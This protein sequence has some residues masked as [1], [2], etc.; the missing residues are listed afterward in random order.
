MKWIGQ[1]K[2]VPQSGTEG[3]SDNVLS[4]DVGGVCAQG[5]ELVPVAQ[6]APVVLACVH[7]EST[8]E[9]AACLLPQGLLDF[10][11]GHIVADVYQLDEEDV[12]HARC[13]DHRVPHAGE[14]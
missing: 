5:G 8:E 11:L 4:R 7:D 13:D 14:G 12:G 6:K 2:R 10:P 1:R 3:T 9:T